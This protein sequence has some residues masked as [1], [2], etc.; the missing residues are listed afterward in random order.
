MPAPLARRLNQRCQQPHHSQ[1][2]QQS[3][4]PITLGRLLSST[5]GLFK[6]HQSRLGVTTCP[7]PYTCFTV[8]AHAT[9]NV[10]PTA[11]LVWGQGY[12]THCKH[13]TS[14][15]RSQHQH[16]KE[17]RTAASM[18]RLCSRRLL[19]T[20]FAPGAP[21]TYQHASSHSRGHDS[22]TKH[23][24]VLPAPATTRQ[25]VLQ[26]VSGG[27]SPPLLAAQSGKQAASCLSTI[28]QPNV[29]TNSTNT[30][31]P[32]AQAS[33]ASCC[34]LCLLAG[35]GQGLAAAGGLG[36]G[37]EGAGEVGDGAGAHELGGGGLHQQLAL[38]PA[39]TA[40]KATCRR[41]KTEHRGSTHQH[42]QLPA[43]AWLG[44]H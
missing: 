38:H 24:P 6:A 14:T 39:G 27:G 30:D 29:Q 37:A 10:W 40:V 21:A 13:S 7:N 32:A 22:L 42:P 36:A 20:P 18:A 23:D 33:R 25:H 16:T 31:T 35:C 34:R 5:P 26:A 2:Y 28:T 17:R 11:L 19:P 8:A 3:C 9:K 12:I 15:P 43:L 4:I 44:M 1:T 41:A